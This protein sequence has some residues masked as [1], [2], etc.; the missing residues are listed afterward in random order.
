VLRVQF[1]G[2][3]PVRHSDVHGSSTHFLLFALVITTIP[4]HSTR[5]HPLTHSLTMATTNP[6]PYEYTNPGGQ[7]SSVVVIRHGERMDE[8]FHSS[9]EWETHCKQSY[10]HDRALY[11]SRINDPPLTEKGKTQAKTVANTL[12]EQLKDA[13][14]QPKVIFS[15]KLIRSLMT[16]YEIALELSLPICVSWGFALTAAAVVRAGKKF[17][18]LSI[19]ELQAMCPG[20][21]LIDGD[22]NIFPDPQQSL[23]PI[24]DD[25]G[26]ASAVRCGSPFLSFIPDKSWDKSVEFLANWKYS[27]VVAH[28]ETIRNLSGQYCNTPYCCYGTFNYSAQ[29]H[30]LRDEL[31]PQLQFLADKEG[32]AILFRKEVEGDDEEVSAWP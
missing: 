17:Q 18:Y 21:Q 4:F 11:N 30:G 31:T 2:F 29:S 20:V 16:A 7:G 13:P 8:D 22:E 25:S 3:V 12:K 1:I 26:T 6:F 32:N 23:V 19:E 28:R 27:M 14:E 15:S 9:H 10:S 24:G 5:T